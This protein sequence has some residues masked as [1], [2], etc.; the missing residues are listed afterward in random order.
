MAEASRSITNHPACRGTRRD[1]QPCGAPATIDGW[2]W[3]HAPGRDAERR[4]ARQKGGTNKSTAARVANARLPNYLRPVL[5]AVLSA[6]RDVRAG[7]L[8]PAQ[9]S[10]IAALA[11]AAVRVVSAGQLEE[12]IAAL[13][14]R[15]TFEGRTI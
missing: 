7:T 2:C 4:A 13:E 9:A 11:G 14:E 1:G 5:G 10:S 12:R 15:G 6:L 8:T 3:S